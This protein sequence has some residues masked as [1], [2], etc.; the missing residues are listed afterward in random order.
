[1]Y[2]F[3]LINFIH[4]SMHHRQH[5]K[6]HKIAFKTAFLLFL[7]LR[8]MYSKIARNVLMIAIIAAPNSKVPRFFMTKPNSLNG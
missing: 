7:A 1:M 8:S 5:F 4:F 2:A 3:L 6:Q